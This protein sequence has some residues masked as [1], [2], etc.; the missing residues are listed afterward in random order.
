MNA[1]GNITEWNKNAE[2]IFGYTRSDVLGKQLSEFIIP[3][4]Y[5][6]AH[7][8]GMKHYFDT[9]E[10]PVLSQRIEISAI[11]KDNREFPIELAITPVKQEG[12]TFF[13]AF[14]RDISSRKEIEA[15][16]ESLL[17]ELES[18][19]Q[20]LS[21]FAYV[22]SHDL[23]APL[24]SIG[25]LS[26]WLAQDYEDVLDD[27]GKDLVKLIKTRT[28][29]MHNLI[30]GVLKYSKVSRQK[31]EKETIDL[32]ELLAEIVDLLDP[33]KNCNVKID[34]NLPLVQYDKIRLHQVFQN[35]ISNAIKF[36]DKPQGQI[37]ISHTDEETHYRF[38]VK[39]NGPG[40]EEEYFQKIF[41][42]FQTI[43][44]KNEYENTGIG[45]SIVKRIIE[46]NKGTIS[47]EST[48]N[49]GAKFSFTV[50][51]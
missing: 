32:N 49:E 44:S 22:I 25:S 10:G 51:K 7:A 14:I 45:L 12:G 37:T 31:A 50:P 46:I 43:N 48:L 23:K 41:Q 29:R 1:D 28:G 36:L 15:Q 47:V 20:E 5:R 9:G 11:D 30:E 26:D 39:D 24:R 17:E 21:D 35:L 27:D 2:N 38:S 33:P 42:I 3:K 4:K 13:S 34:Q 8:Q 16:K 18:V 40:I 6:A 19:N